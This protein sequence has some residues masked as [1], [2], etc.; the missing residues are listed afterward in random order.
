ML[1]AMDIFAGV[2]SVGVAAIMTFAYGHLVMR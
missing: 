1:Q 2:Y